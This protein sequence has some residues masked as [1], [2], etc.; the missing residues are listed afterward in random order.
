VV[1]STDHSI[2]DCHCVVHQTF[3]GLLQSNVTCLKC[4]NVSS[5]YDPMLDISLDLLPSEKKK[6]QL[7]QPTS[8]DNAGKQSNPVLNPSEKRESPNSEQHQ[9][10]FAARR[11]REANSLTDCLDRYA[12]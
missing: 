9:S 1:I 8:G 5:A 12:E 4:G 11:A 3:A 2:D 7:P 10:F 6:K